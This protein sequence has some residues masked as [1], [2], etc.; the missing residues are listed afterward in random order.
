LKVLAWQ[1]DLVSF[2]KVWVLT[3]LQV[4]VVDGQ[5]VDSAA[6]V[7]KEDVL[8]NFCESELGLLASIEGI[9]F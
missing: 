7:V 5:T 6:F 3:W 8:A 2:E 1:L 9:F 4:L